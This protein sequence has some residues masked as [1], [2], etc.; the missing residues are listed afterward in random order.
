MPKRVKHPSRPRDVNQLAHKLVELST[1]ESP[2]FP[3]EP[4]PPINLSEYMA[5]MGRKGGKIGGK[6]RLTTMSAKDRKKIAS[7]AAKARWAKKEREPL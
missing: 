2:I 5:A 6:R 3:T 1:A 4:S 7:K